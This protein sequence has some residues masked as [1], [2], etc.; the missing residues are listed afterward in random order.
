MSA[1]PAW[2]KKLP[3]P[4]QNVIEDV[5]HVG[6]GFAAGLVC[7]DLYLWWREWVKQWP[8]GKPITI[9]R[10][11]RNGEFRSLTSHDVKDKGEEYTQLRRV[12]DTKRDLLFMTIGSTA[13]HV[14]RTILLAIW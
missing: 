6:M 4:I 10:R 1:G 14:T 12:A 5:L 9:Y 11:G 2:F 13:A 3:K 7:F 8:P